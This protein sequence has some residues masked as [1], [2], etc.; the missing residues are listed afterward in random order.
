MFLEK[1]QIEE[2]INYS[3]ENGADFV[4][5]Y[6]SY[7]IKNTIVITNQKKEKNIIE[8]GL[9]IRLFINSESY[10]ISTNNFDI[11]A[12]KKNIKNK[13]SQKSLARKKKNEFMLGDLVINGQDLLPDDF[14]VVFIKQNIDNFVKTKNDI[15]N[16]TLSLLT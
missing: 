2:L 8:N 15:T 6:N 3:L 13:L 5:I 16:V 14:N 9:S 4:E 1:N 7:K 12:I 10:L 11:V